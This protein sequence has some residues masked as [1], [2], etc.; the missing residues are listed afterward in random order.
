VWASKIAYVVRSILLPL[1]TAVVTG[2]V[3]LSAW[4]AVGRSTTSMHHCGNFKF[5]LDGQQPGPGG[6]RASGVSCWFARA[7]ALLGAAPGWHCTNPK[8]ILYVC[9]PASGSAVVKYYGV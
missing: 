5:G 4:T 7:T 1:L 6:I 9:R 2:A 3:A 8:G